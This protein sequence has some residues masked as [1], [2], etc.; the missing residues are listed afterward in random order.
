VDYFEGLFLGSM[1]SDTDFENRRHTGLFIGFGVLLC[2]MI[3]LSYLSGYFSV[4]LGG[5]RIVKLVIFLLLFF[6]SPFLCFRYY[7]MRIWGKLPILLAGFIK[8]AA[9]ALFATTWIMPFLNLSVSQIGEKLLDFLNSTL[10]SNIEKFSDSA[11]SFSTVFGVLT[12]G[13][14]VV[15]LAV[16]VVLLAIMVPGTIILL[17]RQLQYGYDK[18][19]AKFVLT[20][21]IDR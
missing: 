6:A 7:R 19:V 1:W 10:E 20:N 9:F 15:F 8:H 14:Y 13:I 2:A 3:A 17:F 4:L 16:I 5:A 11:G 12:G 21:Q 18:L